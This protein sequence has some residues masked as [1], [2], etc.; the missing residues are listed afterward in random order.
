VNSLGLVDGFRSNST[1]VCFS[2]PTTR[3]YLDFLLRLRDAAGIFSLEHVLFTRLGHGLPLLVHKLDR[4]EW[5]SRS[6]PIDGAEIPVQGKNSSSF[7]MI[8]LRPCARTSRF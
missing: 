4:P 1:V 2:G 5:C 3:K 8:S 7:L 6:R